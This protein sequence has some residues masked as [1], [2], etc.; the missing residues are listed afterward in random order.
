MS[1]TTTLIPQWTIEQF[2]S[3]EPLKWLLDQR[4]KTQPMMF[5]ALVSATQK[6]AGK[7]GI[8]A[9]AFK[10][11]WDKALKA[12]QPQCAEVVGMNPV[13][14]PDYKSVINADL[15][16]GI[17]WCTE[18]GVSYLDKQGA[19][20]RVIKH[21]LLVVRQIRNTDDDGVRYQLA[22]TNKNMKSWKTIIVKADMI[23]NAQKIVQLSNNGIM[24]NS[25]NAKEVVKYLSEII[26]TNLEQIP[27]KCSASHLGWTADGDFVPYANGVEYDGENLTN[28]QM[29]SAFKECGDFDVWLD[30]AK[31][32]RAGK[33]VPARIAL[34]GAFAAPLVSRL[35]ALTFLLHFY[36]KTSMG[37]SVALMFSAS[38]WAKPH[39]EGPYIH[40]F[41][42]TKNAQ[43]GIAAFCGNVPVYLDELQVIADR[44]S[45][46]DMIYML[47]EGSSKPR[48][49]RD[50]G[51]QTIKEWC[52]VILTT[53]EFPI[54]KESSGGGV[55]ARTLEINYNDT[56][57]FE[58][59]REVAAILKQNYGFAGRRFIDALKA[60]GGFETIEKYQ[61]DAYDSLSAKPD[62]QAKQAL[63][64]SIL[65]AA[66]RFADD[67]I[68]HDGNALSESDMLAYMGSAK[69]ADAGYRAYNY[70]DGWIGE[71]PLRFTEDDN[72]GQLW[73]VIE[74]E[75]EDPRDRRIKKKTRIA[76]INKKTLDGELTAAGYNI[77]E[78]MNWAHNNNLLLCENHGVGSG[79]NRRT[80][81][82]RFSKG[83]FT[84][85][86]L[87]MDQFESDEPETPE[88][89][90]EVETDDMP[91]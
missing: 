47:C 77:R 12:N 88:G 55:L 82:K 37:K 9:D 7:L 13:K 54:V 50:G 51:L 61:K 3:N 14:F 70:I 87:V 48:S 81:R 44:K 64:A 27:E 11:E 53:G 30:L 1:E 15:Y 85:V 86:A 17:Y 35:G 74:T 60:E 8:S 71:N 28:K 80:M 46:D 45:F 26:S 38:V 19:M 57:L 76:Y 29:Y 23:S 16:S 65:I 43:E 39:V 69:K 24:V 20:V 73:G 56:P 90:V 75:D 10:R 42:S 79:N 6:A 25:E 49:N 52:T 58:N 33:S 21:P 2:G 34:A 89:F 84:C 59:G 68:F 91:F 22:Y 83:R 41:N 4:T 72:N 36:G 67:V 62:V 32:V 63:S 5:A 18:D 31:S 78:F 66:D 40:S